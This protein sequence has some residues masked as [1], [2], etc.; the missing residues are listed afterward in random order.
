MSPADITKIACDNFPMDTR[1]I[2]N[3]GLQVPQMAQAIRK[4][5]LEPFLVKPSR[6]ENLRSTLYAY[7][8]GKV[9]ILM[10]ILLVD[11]SKGNF[12]SPAAFYGKHAVAVTGYSLGGALKP[13]NGF[14]LRASQIDKIYAHDDQVGPFSRIV[15]DMKDIEYSIEGRPYSGKSMG[16][17]WK[18]EDGKIGSIRAI[19]EILLMPLYHKIRIRFESVHDAVMYFD[20]YI[21][22]VRKTGLM[23][24]GERL[25]WDIYLTTNNDF[26]KEIFES[27]SIH[28]NLKKDALK[29]HLPRY[30]WR[31]SASCGGNKVLDLLFDATDIEQAYLVIYAIGYDQDLFDKIVA[32]A[33]A[34]HSMP[35]TRAAWKVLQYFE[36]LKRKEKK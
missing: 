5:D 21:D 27:N 22:T 11:G 33:K 13:Y 2:P 36:K 24:L 26:K 25:I 6:E 15:L 30:L 34:S 28:G 12:K 35:R 19:P 14:L 18:G 17:S 9:P 1:Y 29:K 3:N 23:S 31:A 8:K 7:I 16:T 20:I 32:I 10:G 4:V